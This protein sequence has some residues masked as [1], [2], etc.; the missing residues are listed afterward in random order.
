MSG[1]ERAEVLGLIAERAGDITESALAAVA[2]PMEDTGSLAVEIA[3]GWMP[4]R[5]EGS[6]CPW[7]GA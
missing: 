7:T 3:V 4:R 5:T 1:G 6:S 2:L